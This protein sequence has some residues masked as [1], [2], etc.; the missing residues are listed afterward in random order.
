VSA[1][2]TL[3]KHALE[4]TDTT[5]IG[6]TLVEEGDRIYVVLNQVHIPDK[7]FQQQVSDVLFHADRMYPLSAMDMFWTEPGVV[8][9]D[10][11][12]PQGAE[13]IENYLGR[14]WRRFSWHRNGV[15]NSGGNPLLDHYAFV[16]MRLIVEGSK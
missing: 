9:S 2:E 13:Q 14:S 3:R 10:G 4:F 6:V 7:A 12:I 8:R 5:G 16:E 11:S 1:I 15:W